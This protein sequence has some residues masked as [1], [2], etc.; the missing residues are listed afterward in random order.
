LVALAGILALTTT[1]GTGETVLG[2]L[3]SVS[4]SWAPTDR[5]TFKLDSFLTRL[6]TSLNALLISVSPTFGTSSFARGLAWLAD[7]L[8]FNELG[9]FGVEWLTNGKILKTLIGG[10]KFFTSDWV[11]LDFFLFGK[12]SLDVFSLLF[13]ILFGDLTLGVVVLGLEVIFSGLNVLLDRIV[14]VGVWILS[15]E[16]FNILL[17]EE[18][19]RNRGVEDWASSDTHVLLGGVGVLGV[20]KEEVLRITHQAGVGILALDATNGALGTG[21]T[22]G[23]GVTL[24]AL[25]AR[26]S[27]V[28]LASVAVGVVALLALF[29][30]G[31]IILDA[32][33]ISRVH[34][35]LTR[36]ASGT[37]S[38]G[39]V[40]ELEA[41]GATFALS[42]GRTGASL[43]R[44]VAL[45]ALLGGNL[46]SVSIIILNLFLLRVFNFVHTETAD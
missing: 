10:T 8:E 1:S 33:S 45:G 32:L 24:L 5:E 21:T 4:T 44:G 15:L 40:S 19:D 25:H 7:T 13:H 2:L 37:G 39:T 36:H 22:N 20:L 3:V 34:L 16:F 46:L 14:L 41:L 12:E 26:T 23:S 6:V 35:D 28:V 31:S 27:L 18:F 42:G 29:A 17:I 30:S 38:T 11:L 9:D 43:A